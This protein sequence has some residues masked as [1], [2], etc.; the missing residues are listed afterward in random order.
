MID[1]SVAAAVEDDP[2]FVL[3]VLRESKPHKFTSASARVAFV[4]GEPA[5]EYYLAN[6]KDVKLPA[7]QTRLVQD[8]ARIG[9][10]LIPQLM[11]EMAAASKVKA[12][13]ADWLLT[14]H[15]R[16][17]PT[18]E[19]NGSGA[20]AKTASGLLKRLDKAHRLGA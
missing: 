14:H 13:A 15:E 1:P 17:R 8:F 6:W 4:A 7:H 19:E 3:K 18:L 2:E 12:L 20:L 16:S 9:S 11:L 10:P 5:L